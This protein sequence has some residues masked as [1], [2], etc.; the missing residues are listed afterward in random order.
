MKW[1]Y[2]FK[3]F[4]FFAFFTKIRPK[5]TFIIV[6]IITICKAFFLSYTFVKAWKIKAFWKG[7]VKILISYE[8]L[9]QYMKKHE[10]TTYKLLQSG[11]DNRTL[12]NLKHNKNITMIT[13]EKLCR[14][15]NCEISDIVCFTEDTNLDN[16]NSN[17][18]EAHED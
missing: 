10:I 2:K 4:Y 7:D 18:K 6:N 11:I 14:I 13:A 8:P 17:E 5:T 16:T 15:L 1:F 3:I 12:H 9:F